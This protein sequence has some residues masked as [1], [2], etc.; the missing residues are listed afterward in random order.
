MKEE[1]NLSKNITHRP[2]EQQAGRNE[3]KISRN[4][5]GRHDILKT[6]TITLCHYSQQETTCMGMLS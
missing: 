4:D 5:D 6:E 1:K 3:D 2:Y